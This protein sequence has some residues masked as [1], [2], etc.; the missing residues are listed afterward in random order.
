MKCYIVM[1]RRMEVHDG[2]MMPFQIGDS[3]P[4]IV[5]DSRREAKEVCAKYN[6]RARRFEYFIRPSWRVDYP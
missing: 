6:E 4:V 2:V 1:R 5:F 3:E